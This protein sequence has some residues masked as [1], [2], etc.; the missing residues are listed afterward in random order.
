MYDQSEAKGFI[1]QIGDELFQVVEMQKRSE[2]NK[3]YTDSIM[4]FHVDKDMNILRKVA[5]FTA[6][7]EYD[8]AHAVLH[9]KIYDHATDSRSRIGA[10]VT[11]FV[12][13]ETKWY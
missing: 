3:L 8:S 6:V 13:R 2:K 10:Y 12:G 5:E 1:T 7:P 4:I 11:R 9:G